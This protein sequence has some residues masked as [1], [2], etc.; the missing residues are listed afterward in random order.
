MR[1][2]LDFAVEA[3]QK[4]RKLRIVTYAEL[5]LVCRYH[6][7][8]FCELQKA[9]LV[10]RQSA[11]AQEAA[12]RVGNLRELQAFIGPLDDLIIHRPEALNAD[13]IKEKLDKLSRLIPNESISKF[14][15]SVSHL[16]YVEQGQEIKLKALN[17]LSTLDTPLSVHSCKRVGIS[18]AAPSHDDRFAYT[19]KLGD[20]LKDNLEVV[21]A[22]GGSISATT[23]QDIKDFDNLVFVR[24][25]RS[26]YKA[27]SNQEIVHQGAPV[28]VQPAPAD[29]ME[30][31]LLMSYTPLFRPETVRVIHGELEMPVVRLIK[32]LGIGILLS[33]TICSV[34]LSERGHLWQINSQQVRSNHRS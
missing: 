17:H 28:H 32:L 23:Q 16:S 22:Y 13:W 9:G 19:S 34:L 5:P 33:G 21:I 2:G 20:I 10:D 11:A 3:E 4:R 1:L 12:L 27:L 29:I 15:N 31:Y 14:A 24:D 7:A 18:A 30:K 6:P 25:L 8:L 26:A